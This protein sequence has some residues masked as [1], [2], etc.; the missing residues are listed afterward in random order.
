[1]DRVFVAYEA[2]T[3]AKLALARGEPNAIDPQ[4]AYEAAGGVEAWS[5]MVE[6]MRAAGGGAVN[7]TARKCASGIE[8]P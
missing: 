1:M 6:A 8:M 4:A 2:L 3:A 5:A 7:S